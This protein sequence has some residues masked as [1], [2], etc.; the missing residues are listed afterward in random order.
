MD[1]TPKAIEEEVD[2][3]VRAILDAPDLKTARL[4]KEA[5]VEAYRE[6]APKAV[7]VLEDG[8]DDGTAVLLL[9]ERYRRR[10]RTTNGVERPG[11]EIRRRECVMRIFPNR[12]SA[13]RLLGVFLMEIDE[14]WTT[15]RKY[16]NM[17]EEEAWKKAQ[18]A[19]RE[20]AQACAKAT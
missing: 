4:L 16:L 10:L 1:A 11:E 18:Q 13:I 17:D 5:F 3:E 9:P 7:Q 6:K 15:E 2:Q 19:S 12:E 14:E 8:F 20:S